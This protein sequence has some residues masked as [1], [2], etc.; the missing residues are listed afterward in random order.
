METEVADERS[1]VSSR[2]H[3]N[4]FLFVPN[5]IGKRRA[6]MDTPYEYSLTWTVCTGYTRI[7]LALSSLYVMPVHPRSCCILYGI[8]CLLDAVDGYAARLFD[9][10]TRFG[11]VLDMVT[12]RCTTTCLLVFLS[13]ANPAWSFVFQLLICLDLSSHHMH[14]YATL[15]MGESGQSHKSVECGRSRLMHLYYTNKVV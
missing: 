13:I 14:M 3:E 5:P 12:D 11:T 8:S 1:A 9:Q 7:I 6:T 2:Q 15:A 10:S 4:V